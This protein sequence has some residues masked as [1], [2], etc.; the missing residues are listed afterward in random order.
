M[1]YLANTTQKLKIPKIDFNKNDSS[2][3]DSKSFGDFDDSF[4]AEETK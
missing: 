1:E 2:N 3:I 4:K